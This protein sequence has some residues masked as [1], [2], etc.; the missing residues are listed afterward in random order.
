MKVAN[1]LVQHNVPLAFTDHLSP[2]MRSIFPDS[3][4]AKAFSSASTKTTCMINGAL[5]PHFKSI[6]VNTMKEGAYSIA[7]DGSNNTGLEKMNPMTVRVYES[8]TGRIVTRFL[9]MCTTTGNVL[10]C[11]YINSFN[12]V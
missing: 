10:C 6:L 8:S 7:V 9:D 1:A 2:L 4:I 12:R 11:V 3:E 5:A